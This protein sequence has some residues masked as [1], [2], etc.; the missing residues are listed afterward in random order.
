MGVDIDFCNFVVMGEL[1]YWGEWL[2]DIL[3]IDGFCLD[4]VKYIFVWFFK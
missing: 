2:L 4:V 3:L 1:M